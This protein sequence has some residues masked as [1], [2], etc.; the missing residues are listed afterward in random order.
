MK[1]RLPDRKAPVQKVFNGHLRVLNW[2]FID[3]YENSSSPE[4]TML[5]KK[6]KSTVRAL[7]SLHLLFFFFSCPVATGLLLVRLLGAISLLL[8]LPAPH[9]LFDSLSCSRGACLSPGFWCHSS[10]PLPLC[11]PAPAAQCAYG[12]AWA[13]PRTKGRAR[14][15]G[16]GQRR[17][18]ALQLSRLWGWGLRPEL[19]SGVRTLLPSP[20]FSSPSSAFWPLQVPAP[21]GCWVCALIFLCLSLAFHPPHF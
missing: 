13:N 8:T 16:Q 10:A 20:S 6:V 15:G 17:N 3:A 2:D 12:A 14:S 5:A 1:C 11:L 9:E 4:F 21:Q 18:A 19:A 7:G